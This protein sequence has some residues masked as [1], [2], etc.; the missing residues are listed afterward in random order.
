[1]CEAGGDVFFST[2]NRSP[3]SFAF[4]IV[5]AEYVLNLVPKGTHAY[6]K[7]IKPSEL[8][9]MARKAGL[10]VQD[11]AG[12]EYNPISKQYF[13]SDNTSVNYLMHAKKLP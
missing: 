10:V 7:M 9:A 3:K 2:I 11:M 1:M 12:M 5:G 6:E 8:A 4:A 13:L